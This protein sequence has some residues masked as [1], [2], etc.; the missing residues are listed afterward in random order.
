MQLRCEFDSP[1]AAIRGSWPTCTS[2]GGLFVETDEVF[3]LQGEA[4]IE[5]V[6][7]SRYLSPFRAPCTKT[8]ALDSGGV[9]RVVVW[10]DGAC[11]SN[12]NSRFSRAGCGVFYDDAHCMNSSCM[13]PGRVQANQRAE[14]LAVLLGVQR[15]PRDLEPRTDSEMYFLIMLSGRY[16]VA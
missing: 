5:E 15:D 3:A 11:K 14:W 8:C 1:C 7:F 10:T 2:Q 13:L 16:Q 12:Q 9:D 6:V 4:D